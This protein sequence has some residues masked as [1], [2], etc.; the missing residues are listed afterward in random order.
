MW[1]AM[2]NADGSKNESTPVRGYEEIVERL[3]AAVTY[4]CEAKELPAFSIALVEKERTI[5]AA[6]FGFQ[7]ADR[8]QPAP[9]DKF[10][11]LHGQLE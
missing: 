5:W 11:A 9:V 3:R 10:N 6:G 4:E 7:D 2:A 8:K 1:I